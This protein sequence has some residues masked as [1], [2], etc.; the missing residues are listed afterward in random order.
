M[1]ESNVGHQQLAERAETHPFTTRCKVMITWDKG[2][3]HKTQTM[4][5]MNQ[6]K[7]LFFVGFDL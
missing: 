1:P 4:S 2:S 3:P 7:C 6:N 5:Q